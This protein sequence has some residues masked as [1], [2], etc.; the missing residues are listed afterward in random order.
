LLEHAGEKPSHNM[1]AYTLLWKLQPRYNVAVLTLK[2]QRRCP[3]S[4]LCVLAGCLELPP[5][6]P[7]LAVMDAAQGCGHE[8]GASGMSRA[9][10]FPCS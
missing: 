6:V 3:A 9:L 2:A 5:R 10:R 8:V 4:A 7:S 1:Y